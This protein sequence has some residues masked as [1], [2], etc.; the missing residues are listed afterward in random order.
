[1]ESKEAKIMEVKEAIE[2]IKTFRFKTTDLVILLK[3]LEAE[4]KR[5]K[6]YE[7]MW[8]E[9]RVLLWGAVI[10]PKKNEETMKVLENKYLGGK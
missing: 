4:N 2:N 5:L 6:S 10:S 7:E 3:S 9:L 1:M 8:K